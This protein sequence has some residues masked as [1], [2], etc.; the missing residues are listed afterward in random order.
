VPAP[1]AIDLAGTGV[2]EADMDKLLQ[3]DPEDWNNEL[4]SIEEHFAHLGRR[5]PQGLR[6]ELEALRKRLAE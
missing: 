3:V 5:L 2:A 6:D 1:G 4:P